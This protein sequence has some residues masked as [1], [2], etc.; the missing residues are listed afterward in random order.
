[1]ANLNIRVALDTAHCA[2]PRS[3]GGGRYDGR[4]GHGTGIQ[5]HG[6]AR[7]GPRAGEG[8][9]RAGGW[10]VARGGDQWWVAVTVGGTG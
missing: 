6:G 2:A 3:C 7:C 5:L 4:N 10:V 8:G 1:M 9:W